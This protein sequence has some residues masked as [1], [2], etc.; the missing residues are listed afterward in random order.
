MFDMRA[1]L[2][3]LYGTLAVIRGVGTM[4]AYGLHVTDLA[5]K[6]NCTTHLLHV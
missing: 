6:L 4:V 2:F 1:I 5:R 3:P